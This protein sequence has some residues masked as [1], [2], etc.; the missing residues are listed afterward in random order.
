MLMQRQRGATT[1]VASRWIR[2]YRI[3][4]RHQDDQLA[5]GNPL[6]QFLIAPI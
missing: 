2:F 1:D 5:I 6:E 4:I 3:V